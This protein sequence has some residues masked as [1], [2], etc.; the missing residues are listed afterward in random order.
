[1]IYY[2]I[3]EIREFKKITIEAMAFELEISVSVY[4]A[5]ENGTIDLKLSK[6]YRIAELLGVCVFDLFESAEL[7]FKDDALYVQDSTSEKNGLGYTSYADACVERYILK[8]KAE[9]QK[10]NHQLI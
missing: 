9:N 2:K 6:V 3:K 5:I 4:S 10:L 1:M 7:K 8:L